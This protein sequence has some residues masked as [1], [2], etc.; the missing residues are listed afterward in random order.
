MEVFIFI[1]GGILMGRMLVR[2]IQERGKTIKFQEKE[3]LLEQ[4]F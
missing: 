2:L 1:T 3:Q 4:V